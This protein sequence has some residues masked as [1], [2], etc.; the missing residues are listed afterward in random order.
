ML[1]KPGEVRLVPGGRKQ[2]THCAT[3]AHTQ[4]HAHMYATCT[5]A[6]SSAR[7]EQGLS[8]DLLLYR[9]SEAPGTLTLNINLAGKPA[10]KTVV[11]HDV[12]V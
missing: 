2:I 1:L 6:S 11:S 9:H 8:A 7:V 10:F 5:R 3:H 12:N 4:E